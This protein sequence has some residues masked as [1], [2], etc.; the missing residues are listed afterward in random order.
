MSRILAPLITISLAILSPFFHFLNCFAL[1]TLALF[2]TLFLSQKSPYKVKLF[3]VICRVSE[4]MF[5]KNRH[6]IPLKPYLE[7]WL[8]H[9]LGG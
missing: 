7:T 6:D 5:L 3:K 8:I 4:I 2:H 9:F 1:L